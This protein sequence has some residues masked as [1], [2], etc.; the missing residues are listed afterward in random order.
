MLAVEEFN[1]L[2]VEVPG[3]YKSAVRLI[4][5]AGLRPA[6]LCG[7]PRPRHVSIRILQVSQIVLPLH[8]NATDEFRLVTAPTKTEGSDRR[9][10]IPDWLC[11]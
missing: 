6:E 10:P 9:I 2:I 7:V 5:L 4:V 11:A 8:G 1:R 3:S